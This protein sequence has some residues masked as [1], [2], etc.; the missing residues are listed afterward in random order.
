[1]RLLSE[2]L[3]LLSNTAKTFC[4]TFNFEK[5]QYIYNDF[6]NFILECKN[7]SP[8]NHSSFVKYGYNT[9]NNQITSKDD[10]DI[11]EL[12]ADTE[13]A[14]KLLTVLKSEKC[15]SL[16]LN[17]D[18]D[19]MC[20]DKIKAEYSECFDVSLAVGFL[21]GLADGFLIFISFYND[22]SGESSVDTTLS[23]LKILLLRKGE[24][25]HNT[26]QRNT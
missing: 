12:E 9:L 7:I 11:S 22:E 14:C 25:P 10:H 16:R 18:N 5:Y 13:E 26:T 23:I 20:S 24:F 4:P 21:R 15:D 1:M 19:Y 6:E 8:N 3:A 17:T 2:I